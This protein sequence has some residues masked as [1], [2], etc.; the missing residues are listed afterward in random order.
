MYYR[1]G[2]IFQN[3]EKQESTFWRNIS[4]G[5][6]SFICSSTVTLGDGQNCGFWNDTWCLE[7]SLA[8]QCGLF[9]SV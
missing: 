3:K 5:L 9:V 1:N 8:R 4:K 6:H 7:I 2:T